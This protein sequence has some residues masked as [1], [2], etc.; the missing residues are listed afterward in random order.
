MT[1]RPVICR[2]HRLL[3]AGLIIGGLMLAMPALAISPEEQLA[4]PAKEERARALSQQLR[5]LVCQNQSIDD[6]D[7]ELA[8][9]LR[10]DV[11]RLI[12]S[13]K[14]DADI[15]AAI[16]AQYGDYVLMSPPVQRSTALLWGLP[17][18]ILIAAIGL[19]ILYRRNSAPDNAP[20][21]AIDNATDNTPDEA[22]DSEQKRSEEAPATSTLSRRTA[23][24]AFL[25][26][27]IISGVLYSYLGRPDLASSP[28]A[29]RGQER[30]EA[31]SIAQQEQQDIAAN[32]DAAKQAVLANPQSVT[33]QMQLALAASAA[34]DFATELEALDKALLLTDGDISL[35]A[36]KAEALSRQANGQI[37]LPARALIAEILAENPDE[38]RA[39][40]LVGLAAY[41][42]E[43]YREAAEIW[44]RLKAQPA[45]NARWQDILTGYIADAANA[46]GF[47]VPD[48]PNLPALDAETLSGAADMDAD[49]Q[50]QM[51]AGMVSGLEARLEDDPSDIAGW[52]QLIQARRVLNDEAGLVRALA[53]AAAAQPDSADAQLALLET[54]LPLADNQRY[55]TEAKTA[56]SRLQR[57]RPD[58]L[59]TL[60]FTGHFAR[61]DGDKDKALSAWTS[62][63][64]R[65]PAETPFVERLKAQ[66]DAL[67]T[68]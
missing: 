38:P 26:I 48:S 53:G 15:L 39:L 4:D 60:F 33:A 24:S 57:L 45:T 66:I 46:G 1:L 61:L 43:A 5:C 64:N 56:L 62:L 19:F 68:E 40:F 49:A 41:Q 31:A 52:Q 11:R 32:F 47:A 30:A 27:T 23:L 34:G 2:L 37:T 67:Q 8:R 35:K 28:L 59:E 54:L 9:D 22:L 51:I 44:Q 42:D 12:I 58:G 17:V 16:Q 50:S 18:I 21:N 13:G 14:S 3:R 25:L 36:L 63:L 20:D 65:L 29:S 6:S 55:R 7:A 10:L